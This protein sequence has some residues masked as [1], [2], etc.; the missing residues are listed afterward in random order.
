MHGDNCLT[1]PRKFVVAR[2]P[3]LPGRLLFGKESGLSP[4][5]WATGSVTSHKRGRYALYHGV[6]ALGLGGEDE[7][8]VPEFH[9]VDIMTALQAAGVRVV[10]YRVREKG[11]V[12]LED[13]ER[14]L[15]GRTGA[16][17]IVHYFGLPQNAR[18]FRDWCDG[19]G[20]FLIED[21]AHGLLGTFEGKPLG[22]WGDVSIF[23][24]FKTLATVDGGL[25]VLKDPDR[26]YTFDARRQR[27]PAL[28]KGAIK[29]LVL[30]RGLLIQGYADA[31]MHPLSER[32]LKCADAEG[33]VNSRRRNYGYLS[34]ALREGDLIAPYLPE[35]PEGACP[36]IFPVRVTRDVRRVHAELVSRGI[37]VSVFPDRLDPSLPRESFPF[38]WEL[39]DSLLSLPCH[40]DLS[41]QD[42][43]R[44]I[45]IVRSVS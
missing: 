41:T 5:K 44:V 15:T 39:A 27:L 9:C 22:S 24:I 18:E 40:Q 43:E 8:L 13:L 36:F 45:E 35:L 3:R 11:E 25:M 34:E 6:R 38:A 37:P 20:L 2:Q 32:A 42:L 7:V 16:L 1:A 21:C 29:S 28:A 23:S 10:F 14:R 12:D 31:R 33:I 4:F 26:K 19:H 30:H 17:L